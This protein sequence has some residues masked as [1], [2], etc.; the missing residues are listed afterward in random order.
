VPNIILGT[1]RLI[2]FFRTTVLIAT[3]TSVSLGATPQTQIVPPDVPG[4]LVVPDDVRPYIM[5]RA[6]GT[7]NYVCMATGN[8]SV[9]WVFH[10]PQATL[11]DAADAQVMTHFL[12]PN[13]AENDAARA[14]WQDSRDTSAVWAVAIA[15]SSDQAYVA[16]GSIPWLLLRVVGVRLGPTAGDRLAQTQY[17][18]RV[19]TQGGVAPAAGCRSATDAGKRALVPYTTDYVFYR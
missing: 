7:Q 4:N 15:S 16:P 2:M 18:Q 9:S 19:N 13:P 5:A 3:I 8:K 6:E 10:G 12:S 11:F 14:T 1:R 17:I